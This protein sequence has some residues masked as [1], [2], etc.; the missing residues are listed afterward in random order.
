VCKSCKLSRFRRQTYDRDLHVSNPTAVCGTLFPSY[1]T[2]SSTVSTELIAVI[3]LNVLSYGITSLNCIL[4]TL[5][6]IKNHK[7]KCL[8]SNACLLTHAVFQVFTAVK[9][10]NCKGQIMNI[11]LSI[12][13]DRTI[14]DSNNFLKCNLI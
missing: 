5:V 14:V 2:T 13:Y 1:S 7:M 3:S 8:R 9:L 11:Y 10:N 4:V 6:N 12:N